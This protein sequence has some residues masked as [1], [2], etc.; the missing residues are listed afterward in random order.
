MPD[1]AVPIPIFL[2]VVCVG[3]LVVL[4]LLVL[5]ISWR[6]SRLE[7]LGVYSPS[8]AEPAAQAPT[9]AET[10][11][12]GA[13]EAFLAQDPSRRDLPKGEQFSAYRRWRQDNGM[14]WTT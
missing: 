6:L 11:L 7:K 13:F 12:G 14:N 10:S 1:S 5:R 8:Q 9:Q 2:L 4:L 3:M